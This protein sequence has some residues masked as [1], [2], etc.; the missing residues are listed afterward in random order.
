MRKLIMFNMVTLDGYF[1]GPNKELDWPNVDEE[2]FEF[3][4]EQLDS[5]DTILFGRIKKIFQRIYP[6]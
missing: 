6:N 4:I 3:A 2:F 1:E 5:A